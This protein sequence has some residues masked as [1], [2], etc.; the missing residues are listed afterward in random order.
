[1]AV[2]PVV[3]QPLME[4]LIDQGEEPFVIGELGAA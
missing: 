1:M 2:D 3:A 4:R